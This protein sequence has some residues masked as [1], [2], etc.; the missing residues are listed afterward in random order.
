MVLR[1]SLR[2]RLTITSMVLGSFAVAVELVQQLLLGDHLAGVAHQV[3]EDQVFKAGEHHRGA[4]DG[5]LLAGEIQL[6]VAGLDPGEMKPALRR[7]RA[8][9][10]ASSSSF[11]NG[12]TR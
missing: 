3:F 10:R 6:V 7:T 4:G 9:R 12:L 11:W 2:S 1:S 5:Q 8:L